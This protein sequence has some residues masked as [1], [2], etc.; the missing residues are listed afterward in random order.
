MVRGE[1]SPLSLKRSPARFMTSSPTK[2]SSKEDELFVVEERHRS[3]SRD[4]DR[5]LA[6]CVISSDQKKVKKRS[7]ATQ[8]TRPRRNRSQSLH[9]TRTTSKRMQTKTLLSTTRDLLRNEISR[10]GK[11]GKA[12]EALSDQ[13]KWTESELK[14]ARAHVMCL[15]ESTRSWSNMSTGAVDLALRRAAQDALR[16]EGGVLVL[17]LNRRVHPLTRRC[18]FVRE[19]FERAVFEREAREFQSFHSLHSQTVLHQQYSN[20]TTNSNTST[21]TQVL[22]HRYLV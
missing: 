6:G 3:V 10:Q 17:K 16:S 14:S 5:D 1:R 8:T 12:L 13:L 22:E 9:M 18:E 2:S 21:R 11:S 4:L 15:G 7:V 20:S 19:V